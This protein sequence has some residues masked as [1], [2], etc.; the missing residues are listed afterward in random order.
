MDDTGFIQKQNS[1]K[2]VVS[3]GSSSVWSKF[4]DANF[5]MTFVVRVSANKYVVSPLLI[6]SGKRLNRDVIEG[7]DVDGANIT[8]APKGFINSTLFLSRLE[9][10]ANSV[11]D[12]VALPLIL[13]YDGC[14]IRYNNK[15]VNKS[16]ELKVI[17][18]IF[19]YNDTH[20]IKPLDIAVF[21]PFKLVLKNV[22]YVSCYRNILLQF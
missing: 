8:T 15:I 13:V 22:F 1:G 20:L 7:C 18:I 16:I 21:K 10:F 3:K 6:F 9:F 12:P 5:H 11:P 4:A 2:A 14:C 17:L 19:P